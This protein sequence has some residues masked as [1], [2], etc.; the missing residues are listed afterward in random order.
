MKIAGAE[1][2][3][4]MWDV[5]LEQS[6]GANREAFLKQARAR[7]NTRCANNPR[8]ET[9]LE[10]FDALGTEKQQRCKQARR[11]ARGTGEEFSD[12]R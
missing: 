10:T 9:I 12:F 4:T 11:I 1:V 2:I 8:R 7:S 5:A 6:L 3:G